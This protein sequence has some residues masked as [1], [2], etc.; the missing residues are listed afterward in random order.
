LDKFQRSNT[1]DS[2][3]PSL[4]YWAAPPTARPAGV[5]ARAAWLA[6]HDWNYGDGGGAERHR[7]TLHE[8]AVGTVDRTDDS[9][10]H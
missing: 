1:E 5:E 3:L 4:I 2:K 9:R 8:D 6:T 10:G 7:E